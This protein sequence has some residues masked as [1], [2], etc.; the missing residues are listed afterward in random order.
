[1]PAKLEFAKAVQLVLLAVF[2]PVEIAIP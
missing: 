2:E 1:M